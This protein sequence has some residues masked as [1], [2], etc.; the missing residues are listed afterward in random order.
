[1][2]RVSYEVGQ[3]VYIISRKESRVYPVL[4]VEENVKRTLEG[5]AVTYM[6]R[7]PDKKGTVIQL[8]TITDRAF[9]SP[10]E[11]QDFLISTATR[12]ISAM[13]AEATEI[14]KALA[15]AGDRPAHAPDEQPEEEAVTIEMPDGTRARLRT[16]N[17]VQG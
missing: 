8:D 6:V 13:V 2:S 15:Q 17:P 4:V 12:S 16:P 11:L 10:V 1:M 9:T 3:V 14:G 5:A 7:L